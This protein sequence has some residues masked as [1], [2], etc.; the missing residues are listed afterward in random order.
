MHKNMNF[1]FFSYYALYAVTMNSFRTI[2]TT[3]QT[4]VP[5][6]AFLNVPT[7][8]NNCTQ[9]TNSQVSRREHSK[10]ERPVRNT[11]TTHAHGL[12]ARGKF[13]HTSQPTRMR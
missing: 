11:D 5:G 2:I 9:I 8:T 13:T 3:K 7:T 4:I 6:A 10:M 1:N 12:A